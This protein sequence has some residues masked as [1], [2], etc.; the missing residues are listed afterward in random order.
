MNTTI[1][2]LSDIHIRSGNEDKSRYTEY[3]SSFNRL[4]K[5]IESMDVVDTVI[6]ITGDIF[7]HKNKIEPYGL[8]LAIYLLRGLA[9]LAPVYIIRGNHDYR[10]DLPY[11]RDTITS[12]MT[13]EI[14]NVNYLDETGVHSANGLNFGLVAIQ[15]TLLHGATSGIVANLPPYPLPKSNAADIN[16]A[17][18]HGSIKGS[19]LQT[20]A[21]NRHGYPIDWFK[22]YRAILLGDIHLQQVHRATPIEID[23]K[24]ESLPYTTCV[25]KWEFTDSCPWAYPGSLIQQDFGEPIMSHGFLVWNFKD[26]TV[27]AHHLHN[28]YGFVKLRAKDMTVF[29]QNGYKPLSELIKL[30]WFPEKLRVCIQGS[31][32]VVQHVS[33]VLQSVGKTILLIK[34][35]SVSTSDLEKTEEQ[36]T[37]EEHEVDK[38]NMSQLMQIN[39]IDLLIDYIQATFDKNGKT[40]DPIWKAWFTHPETIL[41]DCKSLPVTISQKITDKSTKIHEKSVKYMDDF[42]K[43]TSLATVSGT[44]VLHKIEW[45]WILNFKDGNRFEFDNYQHSISLLN[46]K[47]GTGKSNFLEIICIALFGEGFPSRQNTNYS[48]GI[49]CD[50][51]PAGTMANTMILFS[52]NNTQ[53]KLYRV[54]RQNTNTRS[55]NF[56]KIILSVLMKDGTETILH[57]QKP[58]VHAWLEEHIGTID[59]Y[60]MSA[61]LSQNGDKDFFSLEKSAQRVQL[62]KILSL[63]HINSLQGLLKDSSK[64]YKSSIDVIESYYEGILSKKVVDPLLFSELE[65]AKSEL[66]SVEKQRSELQSQWNCIS[67]QRLLQYSPKVDSDR[68][69]ELNKSIGLISVRDIHD[70]QEDVTN[71]NALLKECTSILSEYHSF[72]DLDVF[73]NEAADDKTE[74]ETMDEKKRITTRELKRIRVYLDAHPSSKRL[75]LYEPLSTVI[76][77]VSLTSDSDKSDKAL[78]DTIVDFESWNRVKLLELGDFKGAKENNDD[79]HKEWEKYD[80]I[81]REYPAKITNSTKQLEKLRKLLTKKRKEYNELSERRPN[82]PLKTAEWLSLTAA[83]IELQNH[84]TVDD[85]ML[86]N[87]AVE[88]IP[89]IC[90]SLQNTQHELEESAAYI[91]ECIA[92]PFNDKCKACQQQPWRKK[93]NSCKAKLPVLEAAET[94]YMEELE[95]LCCLDDVELDVYNYSEY[96]MSVR[97]KLKEA[98]EYSKEL[99]EYEKCVEDTAFYSKWLSEFEKQSKEFEELDQSVTKHNTV[100]KEYEVRL[101]TAVLEK[102]NVESRMELLKRKKSEFDEYEMERQR[103]VQDVE[104]CKKVLDRRWYSQLVIYRQMISQFLYSTRRYID[105]LKLK[106]EVLANLIEEMGNYSHMCTERDSLCEVSRVYDSWKRWYSLK[107]TENQLHVKVRELEIRVNGCVAVDGTIVS[108]SRII[109]D[110]KMHSSLLNEIADTFGG[111]REWI[112]KE[113]IGPMIQEKVNTVLEM[114]CD[115]RPLQLEA[116]WLDKIDTLSWFVKDGSSRPV[117]EKTS[118]Y[119]R[120]I[121][122]VACRVAFQ[123]LGVCRIGYQQLFIDEGFVAC[124]VDNL[125]RV[126]DFLRGLLRIYNGICLVTHLEELKSCADHHIPIVRDGTGLSQIVCGEEIGSISTAS[127]VIAAKKKGRP[128]KTITVIKS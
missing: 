105:S 25:G 87:S 31:S 6:V 32:D 115:D 117:I 50:K 46:A 37:E 54:L 30:K 95:A 58:A 24:E 45:N 17:L 41:I 65:Q 125:E 3:L 118:G 83:K 82:R 36:K 108:M 48:A 113:R 124:D 78:L 85:I 34:T 94:K 86:Y 15:D 76:E 12:I 111:Y 23:E 33:D 43:Y 35:Q 126:P 29:C 84:V 74:V 40:A 96:I 57:Q 49:I 70:I 116:E 2:H 121:I 7:H 28:E 13:Y 92:M 97:S 100:V 39:S 21:E 107:E 38:T 44:L 55:L 67:E 19:T 5:S 9:A 66:H 114:I 122:G 112:Y 72:S 60:L 69:K 42:Q 88:K 89:I 47:N 4:F 18:F 98:E 102:N 119:Q 62:D 73:V 59:V 99:Q 79:L 120:F 10:Q 123:Q 103:R 14:P 80:Q 61:M 71:Y 8:E 81:T 52:I 75:S 1:I 90:I 20:T 91:N 51:K 128:S 127:S 26:S 56:E 77:R 68:I 104:H 63:T 64:Y 16:I 106:I 93:F 22:G 110:L 27:T 53:Y 11:A 101:Q 109:E